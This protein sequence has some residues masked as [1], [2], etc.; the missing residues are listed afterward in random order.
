M[1]WL[2]NESCP[3]NDVK[4]YDRR[5]IDENHLQIVYGDNRIEIYQIYLLKNL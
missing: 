4:Y 1:M 2:R 5:R 3:Y